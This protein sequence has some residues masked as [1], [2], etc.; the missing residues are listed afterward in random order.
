MT[1]EEHPV[2]LIFAP[3]TV[4]HLTATWE[5]PAAVRLIE[6]LSSF[7]RLIRFDKRGTGMSD[8]VTNA[9]TIEERTDDIRAVMDAIGSESA[10]LFGASE[11]GWMSS[12]FAAQYPQRTRGLIVWGCPATM[13]RKPD[14]PWGYERDQYDEM[15]R[16]LR[17][18]WPSEEYV[19]TWG[20]GV[21]PDAPKE[22]VDEW[23]SFIQASASPAAIVAL[24][25]MNAHVDVRDVLPSID[26]PTLIMVRDGDPIAPIDAMRDMATRI[27]HAQLLVF[28][29]ASHQ[30]VGPGLDPEPVFSAIEQ[31]VTGS[32]PA[33]TGERFLATILVLDL[34]KSTE[35]AARLGD[36]SWRS[37][38]EEHNRHARH[39]IARHRGVEVNTVGD[40]LLA[41]F[42]G[43]AAAV[44]CAHAIQGADHAIG[45]SAR[46]G[47][48]CGEVERVGRDIRGIAVHTAAR[49]AAA[50]LADEVLVSSTVRDLA[51]GSRLRFDDRGVR[52]LKGVPGTYRVFAASEDVALGPL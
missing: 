36:A 50:A 5:R 39:E 8:R 42:D 43:P 34:V 27:P 23:L 29:G 37:L 40:G 33:G 11:G 31:F 38:L 9:A 44:R 2:D 45:L 19:R 16:R 41:T 4:S 1:G 14:H 30:I 48:H 15:V 28:P 22:L 12:V 17:D 20:A 25:E 21:G 52:E 46:A 7:A 3:G 6:R 10:V 13:I 32:A 47:V 24:E 18:T 51:A 35:H 49:L 26:A